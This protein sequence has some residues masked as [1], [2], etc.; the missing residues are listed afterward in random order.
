M[1]PSPVCRPPVWKQS[2]RAAGKVAGV[3]SEGGGR[4]SRALPTGDG[5]WVGGPGGTWWCH[6]AAP[7]GQ[8]L[9]WAPLQQP[10][11]R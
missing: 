8:E 6:A 9:G 7:A 11:E 10:T 1:Q 3:I 5:C 4:R 2:R